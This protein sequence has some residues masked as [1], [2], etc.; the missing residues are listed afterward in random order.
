MIGDPSRLN[1]LLEQQQLKR[2]KGPAAFE[3]FLLA[4]QYPEFGEF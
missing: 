1:A 3:E 4:R 2:Q